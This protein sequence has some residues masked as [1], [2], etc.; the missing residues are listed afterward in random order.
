MYPKDTK[1]PTKPGRLRLMYEANPI[2]MLV[3]QAAAGRRPARS[4]CWI[5]CHRVAS[6]RSADP[7]FAQ[8]GGADRALSRRIRGRVDRP[9]VSPLFNE[10]SMFRATPEAHRASAGA[11]LFI[12]QIEYW[13]KAMSVRHPIIAVTAPPEPELRP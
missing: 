2:A 12:Q 8:R 4:A 1:D 3:E 9:F 6:A 10:R 11:G 7:G 5:W 13:G